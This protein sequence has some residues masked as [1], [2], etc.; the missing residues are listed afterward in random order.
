VA[1]FSVPAVFLRGGSLIRGFAGEFPFARISAFRASIKECPAASHIP[2]LG[3]ERA[4]K[5][6]PAE[7]A[8]FRIPVNLRPANLAVV[9]APFRYRHS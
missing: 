5:K 8:G 4:D 6:S 7:G 2:A 3:T 9:D 1:V